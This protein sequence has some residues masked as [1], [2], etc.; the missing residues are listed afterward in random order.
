MKTK[1]TIAQ[2]AKEMLETSKN[3]ALTAKEHL[4]RL[5]A[6]VDRFISPINKKIKDEINDMLES[7]AVD[8]IEIAK[9]VDEFL[10]SEDYT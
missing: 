3:N 6:Y 4:Q 9:T 1:K 5:V 2:R 8:V 7:I 10:E